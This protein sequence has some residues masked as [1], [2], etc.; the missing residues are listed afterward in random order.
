MQTTILYH[1]VVI[2]IHVHVHVCPT[3]MELVPQPTEVCKLVEGILIKLTTTLV[4]NN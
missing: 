2:N 1:P 4:H 3:L